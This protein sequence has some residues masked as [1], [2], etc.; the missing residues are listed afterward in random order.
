MPLGHNGTLLFRV[1]QSVVVRLLTFNKHNTMSSTLSTLFS[2]SRNSRLLHPSV[3]QRNDTV[4]QQEIFQALRLCYSQTLFFPTTA[5]NLRDD[6]VETRQMRPQ[7]KGDGSVSLSVSF[8]SAAMVDGVF[9]GH[10]KP[11]VF[12]SS[13]VVFGFSFSG[14]AFFVSFRTTLVQDEK[15]R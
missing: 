12:C 11:T 2:S 10:T 8:I 3:E 1:P 9:R 4:D 6:G 15:A 13:C 5:S 14:P 7:S